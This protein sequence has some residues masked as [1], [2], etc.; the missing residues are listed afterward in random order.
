[1][2]IAYICADP[3]VPVFG[4]KGSSV[5]VQEVIRSLI[6][7]G[8][9]V[10]LFASRFDGPPPPGLKQVGLNRLPTPPKD[11]LASREQALLVA[12]GDLQVALESA[13]PFDLVYE[14]YSLW[15]YAGM[16]YAQ[17]N[18]IPSVLEVNSPLIEEQSQHRGLHDRSKAEWVAEQA[19]AAARNLLA[20]SQEVAHYLKRFPQTFGRT[21][22]IPN[23]VNPERFPPQLAPTL[24][25]KGF[26]VGFVGTLKPWHGLPVLIEAF[27]RLHQQHP[28]TRLLIVGDGPEQGRLEASLAQHNLQSATYLAGG[29]DPSQIP[30]LLA[31]MDVAVAPYPRLEEFYFSPLKVYEYMAAGLPVVAS[32][33]GQLAGLIK[34][35]KTGLLCTPGDADEL[36][37][38]LLRLR[39]DSGL[40]QSLGAAARADVLLDHTW[41]QV[42]RRILRLAQ[43]P[44]LVG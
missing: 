16:A 21:Q 42:A 19:F 4:R 17:E 23:G 9:K 44:T 36:Y 40:G 34:H 37:Q 1:M 24:P 29:V 28:Q 43:T 41:D 22:V 6:K 35:E 11:D 13:A 10:E 12:N 18:D 31:S 32:A 7:Q 30:A 8:A 5:H 25:Y 38:A 33:I 14:R 15:S 20:V 2:R 26:T 27:A 39:S 3:G